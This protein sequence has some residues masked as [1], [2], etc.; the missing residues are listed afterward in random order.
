MRIVLVYAVLAIAV[1]ALCLH[2]IVPLVMQLGDFWGRLLGAVITIGAVAP[3]LRA[4]IMKK[5][6]SEEF[7]ALWRDSRFNHAP[8][9][10]GYFTPYCHCDFVR[11][12]YYQRF[13][14][15]FSCFGRSYCNCG[16]YGYDCISFSQE[17]VNCAGADICSESPLE[18]YAAGI[19]GR[20]ASG[21]MPD[22]YWIGIFT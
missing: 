16:C 17:T 9:D 22:L 5:N 6:H 18:G 12:L 1:T 20:E 3:F 8:F 21:N 14:S 10:F 13:I 2:L 19:F 15:G 11:C 7:R 4:L